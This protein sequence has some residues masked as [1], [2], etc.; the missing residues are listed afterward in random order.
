[1]KTLTL[2]QIAGWVDGALI[3]GV[4]SREVASLTTDSRAVSPGSLFVALKGE[5]HD[6]H[7]FLADV[8]AAGAA[9]ILVHQLPVE[10][11]TYEGGIIR[12]KDTLKALQSL[13]FH[14]R[15]ASP[16]LFVVGVTGSNGK[17]S[18]KDFLSAVLAAGGQVNSTVGNLNN[19]IGLPLTILS[20]RA[21]D[22]FAV[23]EMGMNHPGEI[24]ILAEIAGP[25]AAVITNIGTAHIEH[26]GTRGAIALEKSSLPAAVPASGYCV[27]P[28][29]D[30]Y[31]EFVRDNV[32]CEMIPVG[33]GAGVV[34]AESLVADRDGRMRFDLCS[35][36]GDASEVVLP[37]R[38]DHMVMNALLAA[39]VGLRQGISPAAVATAL[40]G[41][42]LTRGRLEERTVRGIVFIDDSYNANP[43]SM[44]AALRT[45]AS[46]EAR[47][48]RVAV[49][50]FMG[51][52]GPHEEAEHHRLGER[53]A[54]HGIDAL[55][56]VTSRAARINEG[57][58]DLAVN[59]NFEN[60]AAAAEFL[61]DYLAEG[62]LV[63]VKGSR[64]AGME[65]VIAALI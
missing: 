40:S 47:G 10:T 61:R 9:A 20:G 34:R 62:D 25:D 57:A 30:D 48:R 5:R 4:P 36:F 26:M 12:V 29:A 19:H 35:D 64:S 51:E 50:G 24:E 2:S 33:I 56:T 42:Q 37:V 52:L 44:L 38:G 21:G 17:T 39:A 14:H 49:L 63:L 11:E 43:D 59:L 54:A 28:A 27:M 15:R 6:A 46:A 53:V 16:D 13:A 58:A 3:Q 65:Q 41:V 60:H 7:A 32:S 23:W 8:V 22:R 45:L 31:F 1:M 18:T 55:V